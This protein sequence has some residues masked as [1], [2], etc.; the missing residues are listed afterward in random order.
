MRQSM[1]RVKL[2]RPKTSLYKGNI[3]HATFR[4]EVY[5]VLNS[6]CL[7]VWVNVGVIFSQQILG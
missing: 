6:L 5:Y 4:Q 1:N 2:L 7:L 3:S